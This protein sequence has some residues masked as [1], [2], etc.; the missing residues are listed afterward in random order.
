MADEIKPVR[1]WAVANYK[2]RKV[3]LFEDLA[4][5]VLFNAFLQR[6]CGMTARK[7]PRSI[8]LRNRFL[9]DNLPVQRVKVFI[10]SILIAF[11]ACLAIGWFFLTEKPQPQIFYWFEDQSNI[12][13]Q[14]AYKEELSDDRK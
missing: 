4:K 10:W 2:I 1:A 9:D 5:D 14:A 3:E 6:K 7:P 8:L 12:A 11:L 13:A